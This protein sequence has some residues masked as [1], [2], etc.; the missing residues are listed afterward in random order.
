M[1]HGA[2]VRHPPRGVVCTKG[3]TDGKS[4]EKRCVE[5]EKEKKPPS[6]FSWGALRAA[7]SCGGGC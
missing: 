4:E 3:A 7:R 2:L 5:G 6:W 1:F